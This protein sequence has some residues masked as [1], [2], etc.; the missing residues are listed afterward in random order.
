MNFRRTS[1][2]IQSPYLS[3]SSPSNSDSNGS[4]PS[5]THTA[6]VHCQPS[7][8]ADY[9]VTDLLPS[10]VIRNAHMQGSNPYRIRQC[11]AHPT[12]NNIIVSGAC[13]DTFPKTAA[14]SVANS[15]EFLELNL[16]SDPSQSST[17]AGQT[18]C[19]EK[20]E[21]MLP[22]EI[23]HEKGHDMRPLMAGDWNSDEDVDSPGLGARPAGSDDV[24]ILRQNYNRLL[25]NHQRFVISNA[26]LH[27]IREELLGRVAT[28]EMELD[29][30]RS[31]IR[32]LE[33]DK[34][35]LSDELDSLKK[36]FNILTDQM[37]LQQQTTNDKHS[38]AGIK[39]P[40]V[41]LK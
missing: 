15:S 37:P 1:C 16:H 3:P 19:E 22:K 18:N 28:Q 27:N 35:Q 26:Q 34:Q 20:F 21:N 38:G 5:S 31:I 36:S 17:T 6:S 14:M 13:G 23:P 32:S 33:L 9:T 30:A 10:P 7:E 4:N 41:M 11:A 2:G 39:Y 40:C 24:A 8:D 12:S 29:Q 25:E